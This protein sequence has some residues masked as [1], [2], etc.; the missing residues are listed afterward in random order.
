M[1][2]EDVRAIIAEETER[3]VERALS[4]ALPEALQS[5]ACQTCCGACDL[6]GGKHRD[7]HQFVGE[8][9]DALREGRRS[10]MSTL[11]KLLI[12]AVAVGLC[13]YFGVRVVR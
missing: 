7:D 10:A 4:R 1:T 8:V 13:M 12:G 2:H 9:R 3:A 5:S 11:V 6:T